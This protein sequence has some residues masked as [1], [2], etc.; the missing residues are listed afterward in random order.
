MRTLL[1]LRHAKSSWRDRRLDDAD[2]PLAP[3][4]ARAARRMGRY[5][6]EAGLVPDLVLCSTARRAVET[7]ERAAAELPRPPRVRLERALYL[8]EPERILAALAAADA[9]ARRLL[10]VGHNPG[11]QALAVALAGGP[12]APGVSRIGKFPTGALARFA[13]P[14]GGWPEVGAGAAKLVDFVRPRDLEAS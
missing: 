5:L 6:A 14:K 12:Q 3:R 10:V 11:F 8:A 1:L 7:W 4:G 2:R 13:L 9:G